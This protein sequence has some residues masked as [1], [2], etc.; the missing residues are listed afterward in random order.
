[1]VMI[2]I[3]RLFSRRSPACVCMCPTIKARNL[4]RHVVMPL[5]G[6]VMER[7]YTVMRGIEATRLAIRLKDNGT[8]ESTVDFDDT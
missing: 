2:Q 1:M 3:L 4:P 8:K 7:P 5:Q 6:M